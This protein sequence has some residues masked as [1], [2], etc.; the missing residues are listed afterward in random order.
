MSEAIATPAAQAGAT[1][2]P[3]GT[4]GQ[5]SIIQPQQQTQAK[6]WHESLPDDLRGLPSLQK[7]KDQS[8]LAKSYVELEKVAFQKQAQFPSENWDD[9]AWNDF[10]AKAGRPENP[11]GYEFTK[12]E[13]VELDVNQEKSFKEWAHKAGL[14]KKQAAVIRD[15]FIKMQMA[16]AQSEAQSAIQQR[17]QA[18]AELQQR[19]GDKYDA[20]INA[21]ALAAKEF[22]GDDFLQYLSESGLGNDV[23][24]IDVFAKIGMRMHEDNAKG[25]AVGQVTQSA[26][27]PAQAMAEL[28]KLKN[29]PEFIRIIR[30]NTHPQYKQFLDRFT[31][32]NQIAYAG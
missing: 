13:G 15:E 5:P 11:D 10:Y 19:Y 28:T 30:D 1:P 7:F 25:L 8:A 21:A 3:A 29:D 18:Q 22:G 23:R 12:P 32:L 26:N 16:E 27:S 24:V 31:K 4:E 2:Q 6:S 20:A 9:K 14:N 17:E